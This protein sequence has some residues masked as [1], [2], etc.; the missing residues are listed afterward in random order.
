MTACKGIVDCRIGVLLVFA[1]AGPVHAVDAIQVGDVE[2]DPPTTCCLGFSVPIVS[3]DD[4][5]DAAAT[6][7]YRRLGT[8]IW[9]TGLPLLRVRPETTS[10]ETPP[11]QYGLPFPEEQFAGSVFG[12]NADTDYEVR[13]AV[14]DPDGG[15][16][17]QTVTGKTRSLPRTNPVMPRIVSV[18]NSAEL[19]SAIDAAQPG[20]VIELESGTYTGSITINNSGTIDNPIVIRGEDA[21]SVTIDATGASYGVTIGGSHVY[22]ENVTVRGSTWGARTYDTD[23][24]VIRYSRF[25][26]IN[27]GIFAKSGSNR[28]YYIC[29]N[30]L[31]GVFTWPNV[32]SS[33][34]DE[35]GIA[36]SGQG[37]TVC[38]NTVSGFGDALGLAHST[39]IVNA[40]IDFFGND[41]LWTGDDGME[42]DFAHRNVRAFNNRIT[43]AGMGVSLQPVWGG[44]VYIFRNLFLNLAYSP[45]KLNNDPSGFYIYHNTSARTVGSGNFG[46][47]AWPQLGYTQADGDPAYAANFRFMNNIVIGK[48]DPAQVTT[49]ILLAEIDYNGWMPDGTFRIVGTWVNFADLQSNSSYEANGRILGAGA[50]ENPLV[51]P[52]DY[53]TFWSSVNPVLG[54]GSS[55][56]DAGVILP[57]IND[58]FLGS[59]PDIGALERGAAAVTYGVRPQSDTLPPAAPTNVRVE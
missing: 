6:L 11:S 43:N 4:N 19:S 34:W 40:S 20:D 37:H 51:L 18:T 42:L 29:D 45:Y 52:P 3:G 58:G 46:G 1:A 9:S 49:D 41:V 23:G 53:T 2:T 57:N 24:V 39:D 59:A 17:V 7:E 55:A 28:N 12:L 47:Y 25:I 16:R 8:A 26:E 14:T 35:E 22:L 48:T 10:G 30:V 27:R 33:T 31:E 44:P 21:S 36:I 54:Q 56:A 50:F 15:G 32:S 13:I 5:Y 38:H